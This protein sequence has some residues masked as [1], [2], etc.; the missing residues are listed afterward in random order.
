MDAWQSLAIFYFAIWWAAKPWHNT[1]FVKMPRPPLL[2]PLHGTNTHTWPFCEDTISGGNYFST[3]SVSRSLPAFGDRCVFISKRKFK[4]RRGF[5]PEML[6]VSL[7]SLSAPC[8]EFSSQP[9]GGLSWRMLC[10]PPLSTAPAEGC[11]SKR[12]WST[13]YLSWISP[14]SDWHLTLLKLQSN[15]WNWMNKG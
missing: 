14:A 15:W 6:Y 2:L 10:L 12:C 1:D 9:C 5:F 8:F 4:A 13:F 11:P 7:L 3:F